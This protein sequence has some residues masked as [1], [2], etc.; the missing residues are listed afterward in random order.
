LDDAVAAF[1]KK[2][3]LRDKFTEA[4]QPKEGK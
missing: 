3:T 1:A 4:W 2:L